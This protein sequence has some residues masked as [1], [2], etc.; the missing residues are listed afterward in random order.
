MP[1]PILRR[2]SAGS[3]ANGAVAVVPAVPAGR[4]LVVSK[5]SATLIDRSTGGVIHIWV[6]DTASDVNILVQQFPLNGG[7]QYTESGLV[8][9]AGS[10]VLIAHADA[11]GG[12]FVAGLWCQVFGEE[13]DN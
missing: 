4:A 13:V 1:A 8:I 2:Y 6:G 12:A 11:V 9:P 7:E 5:L 3:A 10:G